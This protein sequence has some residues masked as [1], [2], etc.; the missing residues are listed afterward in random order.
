MKY[1]ASY[2]TKNINIILNEIEYLRNKM[3]ELNSMFDEY[4]IDVDRWLDYRKIIKDEINY[5]VYRYYLIGEC[6]YNLD[7]PSLMETMEN[8]INTV[9]DYRVEP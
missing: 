5:W 8:K 2:K 4:I 9:Y 1:T 6:V 3:Y 7:I